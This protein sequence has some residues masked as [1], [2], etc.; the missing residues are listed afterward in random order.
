MVNKWLRSVLDEARTTFR[1]EVRDLLREELARGLSEAS[2]VG[3]AMSHVVSQYECE[4]DDNESDKFH[5]KWATAHFKSYHAAQTLAAIPEEVGRRGRA[6]DGADYALIGQGDEA[7]SLGD[8]DDGPVSVRNREG[9]RRGRGR[10]TISGR[11]CSL[12]WRECEMLVSTVQFE[13][14]LGFLLICNAVL[15]GLEVDCEM[16]HPGA[17]VPRYYRQIDHVL[18][19]I[20]GVELFLRVMLAPGK[21]FDCSSDVLGWNMFDALAVTSQITDVFLAL[22]WPPAKLLRCV[23]LWRVVRLVPDLR[24]LT[25]SILRSMGSLVWVLTIFVL[26]LHTSCIFFCQSLINAGV[27]NSNRELRYWFSSVGRAFMTMFECVLGGVSWDEVSEAVME[28]CGPF[29]GFVF[30]LFIALCILT[31]LNVLTGIFVDRTTSE[32]NAERQSALAAAVRDLFF[33]GGMDREI[34][35][36]EFKTKLDNKHMQEYF[37][38]L[39]LDTGESDALFQLLDVDGSGSV[40]PEEMVNGCLRLSGPALAIEIALLMKEMV[41]LQKLVQKLTRLVKKPA[42]DRRNTAGTLDST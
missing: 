41:H 28:P 4:E 3:P 20:F 8:I 21:F 11:L 34:T 24:S 13:W 31:I 12:L 29:A 22:S 25:G 9:A 1:D 39:D 17:E 32:A 15:I 5:H 7:T 37:Q 40:S 14:M 2:P 16:K 23:R 26:L 33:A 10:K 27:Q 19:A 36:E 18:T 42:L 35:L 6:R 30:C 38:T